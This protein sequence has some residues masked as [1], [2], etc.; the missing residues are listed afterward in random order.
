MV[1]KGNSVVLIDVVPPTTVIPL[2]NRKRGRSAK[3]VQQHVVA[4]SSSWQPS[5]L[6]PI[7]Q[8]ASRVQIGI[9]PK[10]ESVLVVVL[11][12]NLIS[13]LIEL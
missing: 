10:D 12:N 3:T 4:G 6:N 1:E 7:L 8:L 9:S 5:M 2:V 13:E 11:T